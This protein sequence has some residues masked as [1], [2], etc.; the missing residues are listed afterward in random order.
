MRIALDPERCIGSGNCVVRLPGNFALDPG[1]TTARINDERI[2]ADAEAEALRA[3]AMCPG[4][5]LEL[6]T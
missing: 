1:T 5:A 6:S 4:G 2:A 3:V